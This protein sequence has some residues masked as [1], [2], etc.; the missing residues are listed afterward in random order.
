MI[1]ARKS[2]PPSRKQKQPTEAELAAWKKK[3]PGKMHPY[4][5]QRMHPYHVG[6]KQFVA[7]AG[8]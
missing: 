4:W 3:N 2:A 7:K 5:I 8:Q 6:D 1:P